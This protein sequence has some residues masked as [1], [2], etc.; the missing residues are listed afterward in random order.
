MTLLLDRSAHQALLALTRVLIIDDEEPI[1]R[2]LGYMLQ[3]HGYETVL[4]ADAREARAKIDEQPFALMLCDV[5][6]PGESGMDLARNT[7]SQHPHTAVIMVT[8]LDSSVLANAA[9]DMGA[10]GYIVKPF[11]SNEVM[12][13]VANALRRRRLE[14]ENRMHR[15][16]LEEIGRAHV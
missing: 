6:M 9:L 1:R 16:N 4:V 12:I 5:N 11:E 2:L 8:G 7:L 14:L 3:S 13:D 15:E 10:F